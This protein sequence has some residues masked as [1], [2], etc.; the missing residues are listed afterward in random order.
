MPTDV[1]LAERSSS[2]YSQKAKGK[3]GA[4]I[5][6]CTWPRT[7]GA[8]P[9]S[10]H[11]PRAP[12]AHPPADTRQRTPTSSLRTRQRTP[13]QHPASAPASRHPSGG[14]TSRSLPASSVVQCSRHADARQRVRQRTA[15]RHAYGVPGD[16]AGLLPRGSRRV[17][18]PDVRAPRAGAGDGRAAIG[19]SQGRTVCRCLI[20]YTAAPFILWRRR[21]AEARWPRARAW[22]GTAG[23][24]RR[25][26]RAR[27]D[28]FSRSP[29]A[30]S[31][32]SRSHNGSV[33]RTAQCI[34]AP[35]A[36]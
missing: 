14:H 11:P 28:R 13:T 8:A 5:Q 24:W 12:P 6:S 16:Y 18:I 17:N 35:V 27:C 15:M 21:R 23:C 7:R 9:T 31:P 25:N 34:P 30:A 29:A 4:P 2:A 36:R 20:Q 1:N 19:G 33:G 26:G 10:G 3:D 22:A 32:V